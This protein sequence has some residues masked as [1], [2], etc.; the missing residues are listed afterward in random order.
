MSS[1]TPTDRRSRTRETPLDPG[2][3]APKGRRLSARRAS[4]AGRSWHP[5][6]G[7]TQVTAAYSRNGN[8]VALWTM[9]EIIEDRGF[10]LSVEP[11]APGSKI[12]SAGFVASASHPVSAEQYEAGWPHR[13]PRTSSMTIWRCR[14][15]TTPQKG[16]RR[17]GAVIVLNRDG[18]AGRGM[19]STSLA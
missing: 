11:D 17:G 15:R 9:A 18:A 14:P 7:L 6:I 5:S 3:G 12:L 8:K 13:M 2:S 10:R 1:G 19:A 4:C 16:P